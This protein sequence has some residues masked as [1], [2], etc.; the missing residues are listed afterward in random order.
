MRPEFINGDLELRCPTRPDA[1]IDELSSNVFI[2]NDLEEDVGGYFFAC[3]A[4]AGGVDSFFEAIDKTCTIIEALSPA[5]ET[6]WKGIQ[7]K[8]LDLG[9]ES[10]NEG[11]PYNSDIDLGR[12]ERLCKLG[13]SLRISV[14]QVAEEELPAT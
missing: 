2:L 6:L 12:L 11:P 3:E 10:G 4:A 5:S 14:Y 7:S 1:L 8:V 13:I 9:F